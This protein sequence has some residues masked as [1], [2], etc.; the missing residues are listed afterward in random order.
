MPP[1]HFTTI[2]ER[3]NLLL[4]YTQSFHSVSRKT[5]WIKWICKHLLAVLVELRRRSV[6]V[7]THAFI[8]HAKFPRSVFTFS[9]L[10]K[11]LDSVIQSASQNPLWYNYADTEMM[12]GK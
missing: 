12:E 10:I 5:E 6:R 3:V 11:L 9:K 4:K 1:E 2:P 8:S 7:R